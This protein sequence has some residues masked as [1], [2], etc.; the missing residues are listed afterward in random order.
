M[1]RALQS[2]LALALF[3]GIGFVT[4]HYYRQWIDSTL[5]EAAESSKKETAKW[6]A[7]SGNFSDVKF[8]QSIYMTPKIDIPRPS[9]GRSK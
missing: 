8:D 9:S 4:R 6:K 7:A 5:K 3:I 1:S 2:M